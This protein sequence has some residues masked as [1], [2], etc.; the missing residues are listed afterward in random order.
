MAEHKDLYKILGLSKENNPSADEIKKAYRKM[1]IEHHPDRHGSDSEE[2]KQKHE[3]MFKEVAFAYS[4][5]SDPKKKERYDRFGDTGEGG[6]ANGFDPFEFFRGHFGGGFGGFGGFDDI[7]DMF[8]GSGS[9][10]GTQRHNIVPGANIQMRIPLTLEDI[11]NGVKKKVKFQVDVRCP[12][13]HGDGGKTHQCPHCHGTGTITETHNTGFGIMQTQH[14]CQYCNGTGKIVDEK[15]HSCGG[16]GFIKKDKILEI[17]LPAGIQEGQYAVYSNEGS[18]SRSNLGP[19]G[20]FIA[21][22]KYDFDTSR[23][24]INGANVVEKVKIPYYDA[25]IGTSYK[26][27]IP[28][29]K[30]VSVNIAPG[31][32]PGKRLALR[33]YGL[34]LRDQMYNEIIGDYIIEIVYDIPKTTD[35]EMKY[36]RKIKNLYERK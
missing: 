31:T 22:A 25:I 3:E 21:V 23:Y 30:E 19:N 8:G 20:N 26:V 2:E 34:K 36:L 15:C 11:Y 7:R 14:Q 24:S 1:S 35:D 12:N 5:L 27:S 9:S 16:S 10:R 4:I 17:Q 6:S 13:C 29:G 28:N 18:E 32:L 33:E